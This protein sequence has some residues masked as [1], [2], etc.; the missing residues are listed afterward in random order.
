MKI[1]DARKTK[2]VVIVIAFAATFALSLLTACKRGVHE[3]ATQ[4]N[5]IEE[6]RVTSPDGLFDA[7]MIRGPVGGA[8]GGV[9]WNVFIV[10][11]AAPAPKGD[12]NAVLNAAVLRGESL[13]WKE[14]H[15]LE[16]HYVVAHIEQFRNIWGSNELQSRGWRKGDYLAEVRLVPSSSDF[17]FLTVDG[18]FKPTE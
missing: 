13:V 8:L 12:N 16:I 1:L 9:Y 11:K 15:L 7:V 4:G 6:V 10:P 2:P 14:N 18:D 5:R 3:T 17:S